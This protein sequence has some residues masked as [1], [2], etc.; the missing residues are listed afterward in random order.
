MAFI[1]EVNGQR[2]EFEQEP[3]ERDID[4]AARGLRIPAKSA[5]PRPIEGEG[6]AAFGVYRPQGRRPESQ[7]DREA[8]KEMVPQT[9]RGIVSNVIGLPGMAVDVGNIAYGQAIKPAVDFA[10]SQAEQLRMPRY[11]DL[12]PAVQTAGNLLGQTYN[13]VVRGQEFQPLPQVPKAEKIPG[14]G[15]YGMGFYNQFVPGPEPTSP[16]GQLAFAGGQAIGAPAASLAVKAMPTVAKGIKTAA[17]EAPRDI[18]KGAFGRATG[19]IAEPGVAPQPWQSQ[20][21]RIPLGETFITPEGM[22]ELKQGMPISESAIRP[23][24]ELP[25]TLPERAAFAISGG[26]IPAGGQAARAFGERL[27]ETYTNPVTAAIDLGSA[28]LTGVPF[29]T[30]KKLL[31]EAVRGLGDYTMSRK[32]FIPISAEERAALGAGTNPWAPTART[33]TAGPVAPT[34]ASQ[35]PAP[36]P[37]P[38]PL[39]PYK[40]TPTV[41]YGTETGKVATTPQAAVA[42]DLAQRYAPQPVRAISPAEMAAQQINPVGATPAAQAAIETSKAAVPTALPAVTPIAGETAEQIASKQ[43]ILDLINSRRGVTP[44]PAVTTVVAE[45]PKA[46]EVRGQVKM[47]AAGGIRSKDNIVQVNK[48][49][50]NDIAEKNGFTPIDWTSAPDV[51]KMSVADARK[52]ITDFVDDQFKSQYA[53]GTRTSQ[54]KLI[55][56]TEASMTPEQM[57]AQEAAVAARLAKSLSSGSTLSKTLKSSG[58]KGTMGI[59]TEPTI[60]ADVKEAARGFLQNQMT[61]NTGMLETSYRQGKNIVEEQKYPGYHKVEIKQPNGVSIVMKEHTIGNH[62][63]YSIAT[64][65]GENPIPIS[66]ETGLVSKPKQWISVTDQIGKE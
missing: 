53:K 4:E 21:S 31:G 36:I 29:W 43:A 60:Y 46:S 20:S 14:I 10:T 28:A 66:S 18:V 3:T 22:A 55:K 39:L 26:E 52:T 63:E 37:Q 41:L 23:T 34:V 8:S 2:V 33:P 42:E 62:K 49:L 35:V 25:Q 12:P 50:F 56:E 54:S 38:T 19:S 58:G 27:G 1:Y 40:P 65:R 5:Q 59:M 47:S 11:T 7:Q 24:S 16:Q 6:G 51:S 64:M 32:G 61:N 30:T 44:T 48:T 57:A 9:V 15:E 13:T 45:A 17:Y